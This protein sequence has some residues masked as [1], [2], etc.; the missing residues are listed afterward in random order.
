[1]KVN[2]DKPTFSETVPI[3]L[4]ELGY[5]PPIIKSYDKDGVLVRLEMRR[6]SVANNSDCPVW[7]LYVDG[8]QW[9]SF[10]PEHDQAFNVYSHYYL[11]YGHV[12]CTGLGFGIRE[13]WIASKPEVTK[14]TVLEK[15]KE[16][17]DY[18]KDIGTK[19]S[20]KIEIINCD[21]NDY[22]GNCDFLS[23]DHYEFDDALNIISSIKKI[24]NN[25]TCECTWF[26]MLENWIRLGY[27]EDNPPYY[28][29][30]KPKK[31][32]YGGKE[33]D[34]LENYIKIKKYFWLD[35]LPSLS[36]VELMKFINMY[37]RRL[38]ESNTRI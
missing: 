17:I 34:I 11:A 15:F 7:L 6:Y 22:K 32:S 10:D 14:V 12:I 8:I 38:Y 19:W 20:D 29:T 36:E 21:A 18:H 28:S 31:T 3:E 16:V 2:K 4:K 27:I 30:D 24:S 26:W 35:K 1:M 37:Y 13:Q 33:N 5:I 9:M 23:I 25:I